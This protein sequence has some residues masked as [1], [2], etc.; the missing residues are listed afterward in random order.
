LSRPS[1]RHLDDAELDALVCLSWDQVSSSF[2]FSEPSRLEIEQHA[3]SCEECSRKLRMHKSVQGE[4][5]RLGITGKVLPSPDCIGESEWLNAAAGMLPEARTRELMKHAAQ[6]GY[7]G[8]LLRTAAESLSDEATPSEEEVLASLSSARPEWQKDMARKLTGSIQDSQLHTQGISWWQSLFSRPR[9]TFAVAALAVVA[10]ASWLGMRAL[11]S[12]S[13]ERL[14]A[15]AYTEHRTLEMRIS[16]ARYAPLRVERRTGGSSLDKSPTLLKAEA[17]IGENLIKNPSDPEWLQVKARADLIDGNYESAIKSLQRALEIRP[18]S[19]PLLTDLGSAYFERGEAAGRAIDYGNAVETFSKALAKS[20][21]DPVALYNRALAGERIFLY[22]QSID[23]WEHYLRVDPTGPWADDV[24]NH[25]AV[26]RDKL[27]KHDQSLNAP[28]LSPSELSAE[29]SS[30]SESASDRVDARI[31]DYLDLAI[32]NW[33]PVAFP[34]ERDGVSQERQLTARKALVGLAALLSA[35]HDDNWLADFMNS[36][37]SEGLDASVRALANSFVADTAGSPFVGQVES[38]RAEKLFHE[39]GNH[40]G[41]VRA[42]MEEMYSQH[43]LFHSKECLWLG[44]DIERAVAGKH[45]SWIETELRLEQFACFTSQAKI[46]QGDRAVGIALRLAETFNYSTLLLR[47]IGFAAGLQT[48]KNDMVAASTWDRAGLAKYWTGIAPPLRAYQFYDDLAEQAQHSAQWH[49][50][51]GF[52]REATRAISLT[53]NRSGEGMARFQLAIST[54]MAG[55][56]VEAEHESTTAQ[57]IFSKLAQNSDNR[58]YEADAEIQLAEAEATQGHIDEAEARLLSARADLP[59]ALDSFTTWL[60]YFRTKALIAGRR[61]DSDGARRDCE[62]VVAIGEWGLHSILTEQDRLTWNHSTSDCYR[63]LVISK[64]HENDPVGALTIWEWYQGSAVRSPRLDRNLI[65]FSDLER[66][67]Q[68][69]PSIDIQRGLQGLSHETVLT[70]AELDDKV[71]AWV[72]DDRGVYLQEVSLDRGRVPQ[73]FSEFVSQ[74]T[75]PKSDLNSLRANGRLLYDWLVAPLAEHLDQARTLIIET[76]GNLSAI[77]FQ[78]LVEPDGTYLGV[79]RSLVYAPGLSY[80]LGLRPSERIS[81]TTAALVVGNP[82]ISDSSSGLVTLPDAGS[83]ARQIGHLFSHSVLLEGKE[84]TKNAILAQLGHAVI[85]HFAGHAVSASDGSGLE[86]AADNDSDR[87]IG[88]TLLSPELIARSD[89]GRLQLAVLSACAT[90]EIGQEGITGPGNIAAAFLRARVPH[91]IASRW[92]VDSA[93]TRSLMDL[94]YQ[95]LLSGESVPESL[96]RASGQLTESSQ[97]AHPYYWA[98]FSVF[99]RA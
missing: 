60:T 90:G 89:L 98:A 76:D 49:L 54:S 45:Y 68:F 43:R 85:F 19:P 10:V 24:R 14:L 34:A 78:A 53:P 51:V 72:Y 74:C 73:L 31:E 25:L 64:L 77:P 66:N 48:D 86:V 42:Q 27:K 65:Q 9:L 75:D 94:V 38:A 57:D 96:R 62:A 87:A 63:Q 20:P 71:Y 35:R 21:D 84:A 91:V 18:E 95:A 69:Q 12:Q 82:A 33:L 59:V 37:P 17:L 99:G 67:S 79:H 56:L 26:L 5:S 88:R 1:D 36:P 93:A 46:E 81:H 40:P 6:C 28:L 11:R 52:G 16:G 22:T 29:M 55:D 23:D 7:C 39:S 47:A 32:Q 80:M 58:V 15:E 2:L 50:A 41:F 97:Y 4:I 3:V 83:E 70:Y 44:S 13:A 61:G 92:A 8:P 30:S